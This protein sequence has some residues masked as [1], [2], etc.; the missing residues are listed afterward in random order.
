[1]KNIKG[2]NN[3]NYRHGFAYHRLNDIYQ[4][5]VMRCTNL[6]SPDYSYYGNRG[7]E[8]CEKW[9]N[10]PKEFF[11]WAMANG[12]ENKLTLDRK[13]NNGNYTPDNCRWITRK[14]QAEN[15][16]WPNV[17]GYT[18]MKKDNTYMVKFRGEYIGVYK[19]KETARKAYLE[20]RDKY[21]QEKLN[22][23]NK[24]EIQS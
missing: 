4:N 11:T 5:M 18:Y 3:P 23:K 1:M 15:R 8:I 7:I 2:K 19:T 9:L 10:S 21:I 17:K 16:R 20:V 24:I 12:Y 22:D 14:E 13:E 6:N